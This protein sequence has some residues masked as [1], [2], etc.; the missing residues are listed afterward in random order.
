MKSNPEKHPNDYNIIN[1]WYPLELGYLNKAVSRIARHLNI[2]TVGGVREQEFESEYETQPIFRKPKKIMRTAYSYYVRLD[3][4]TD[5]ERCM[6]HGACIGFDNGFWKKQD[7][8][9]SQG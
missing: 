1:S 9:V 3:N 6:F 5:M 4:P 7:L 2:K 8:T